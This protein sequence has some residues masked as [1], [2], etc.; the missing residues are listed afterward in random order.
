MRRPYIFRL[1]ENKAILR[2]AFE[3]LNRQDLDSL[4]ELIVPEYVDQP[5]HLRGEADVRRFYTEAFK[6]FPDFHATLEE[7]IAEGDK[8]WVRA[9]ITGTHKG[10]YRGIAPT[11][12]KIEIP[13]VFVWR[14]I[15][16]KIA[17]KESEVNSMLSFYKQLGVIEYTEKG[18][19]LFPEDVK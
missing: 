15:I 9:T 14:I 11:G 8:V 7:S 5:N 2:R 19:K 12:K 10:E 18:K 17:E 4:I 3:A 1:E 16:G 6:G 13:V